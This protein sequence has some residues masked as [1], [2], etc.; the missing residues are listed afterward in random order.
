MNM[1]LMR[2]VLFAGMV[3]AGAAKAETFTVVEITDLKKKGTREIKTTQELA[4]LKKTIDAE[5]QVFQKAMELARKDWP[6]PPK[7]APA[8]KTKAG[9]KPPPPPPPPQPFPSNLAPRKCLDKGSFP[10]KELAQKLLDQLEKAAKDAA[11]ALAKSTKNQ[12]VSEVEKAR[13]EA[14]DRGAT[15][16]QAK[17]D[18]LVKAAA[19]S[20][21]SAPAK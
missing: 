4:D 1:P 19:S 15:A 8:A 17:L 5:S 20:A 13:A 12:K 14:L 6:A 11:D 2:I 10:D 3:A 9:T 18:E 21:T 16:V 7:P